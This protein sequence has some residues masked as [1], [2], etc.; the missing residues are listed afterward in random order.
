VRLAGTSIVLIAA[1]SNA[2]DSQFLFDPN[3]NLSS[4]TTEVTAPPQI[5]GQPRNQIVERGETAAFSVVVANTRA[6]AYQWR[7]NGADIT[8]AT[9]DSVVLQNV[10]TNSEGAYRVVL[11]NPSGSVTSAPAMLWFDGNGNGMAD[12]WELL[13]F[14]DLN[15]LPNG[16]F[17]GD[18]SLNLQEFMN[19]T[20]PTDTNSVRFQLTVVRVGGSVIQTPDQSS[21][22]NGQT[23]TLTA[24]A[25]SSATFHAFTGDIATR[26]NPVT[27]VMTNNKTVYASFA[28]LVLN[29][30]NVA[31]GDWNTAA[32][33]EPNLVPGS[34]DCVVI[35]NNVIVTLNTPVDCTDVTLGRSGNSVTTL[36]GSGTLTVHGK[37]SW[38]T[39][40]MSGSGR[41]V[42]EAGSTLTIDNPGPINLMGRA[43]ENGGTVLWSGAGDLA[44]STG[45]VI[46]NRP[47]AVFEARNGG[48]LL[49]SSGVNRFDNAGIFR[50]SDN[51][52][53][54][55]VAASFNNSGTVEIQAGT[56]LCQGG[57]ANSGAVNLSA[58]TT[59]RLVA[60]GSS[61]GM[62]TTPAA[63]MVEW[64]GGTF[65]LNSGAQ[66]NGAGL[67]RI[68]FGTVTANTD[69]TLANLDI[70]GSSFLDGPGT[71]TIANAMNWTGGNM[72]GN[73]R[74]VIPS[75]ATL[76]AAI[77]S[78][79]SLTGR[80]LE[81][82]GTVLWSG[83]GSL[84]MSTGAFITNR[85]GALFHIQNAT[86]LGTFLGG[87]IDNAGI[88]RK[89][90]NAGTTTVP[91]N[92]NNAGT[93][94]IE[95]GT[96][97]CQG[98][99]TNT[100]TVSL[101][102]GTTNRLAAGGFATGAFDTATT[103]MVEWTANNF[104]LGLGAQ[105]NGDGIYRI[106]FG[107]VTA[108]TSLT[109]ENLDLFNGVLAG[110]G[111][112]TINTLMNWTGGGMSGSG[113]TII[114]A[115]GT[116]KAAI[117]AAATLT[118][119]TFESGGTVLWS[120]AGNIGVSGGAVITNRPGA[121]FHV[122]NAATLGDFF[123]GRI[124]NAG[125]FR[126][127][128]SP[129]STPVRI[130]FT[131]YG[132]VDIRS[133]ILAANGG[134][135][136]SPNAALN[137]TLGGTTAGTGYG[138][139]QVAGTVALNGGL[140]VDLLP[141]F[142]PTTNDTFT[143]VTAGTRN[144]TFASFSYPSNVVTMQLSDSPNSVIVQVTDVLTGIPQPVLL[145]PELSGS[146]LKLTWTSVSNA[147]YRVEFNS[148]LTPSNWT[149]LPGDVMGV[150]NTASKLDAL[151]GSNRFYRVRVV[152]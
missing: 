16:D 150:S 132:T 1:F 149:A 22:A 105:L 100:G 62:F 111:D 142:R 110:A 115:G 33:W 88:F 119:R 29:W 104:V 14:G 117:P 124:D 85:P 17:D 2:Q 112:V 9:N 92:F 27:L 131:N 145:V 135:V 70:I 57:F 147:I 61:S 30:T 140:S 13:H 67:Y 44:M 58:G 10:G 65:A 35:A 77:P 25:S 101:S 122:L 109:V 37:F 148:D 76:N 82:G 6:L 7:F 60:G 108:N 59:H 81:N 123:G 11:T 129:G 86:A 23:V 152:P 51:S 50:K 113:R 121:L 116:L 125:V 138:Q 45:A 21:Y 143:V 64:T 48:L 34:K 71:V 28:P 72:S 20:D 73:G 38:I 151:T 74:T 69:L 95:T 107:L 87:R 130:P 40:N 53:T 96:L 15:Q 32:N 134:Y 5:L 31:D 98:G 39:G 106:N 19:D 99:F 127:S 78:I 89:S 63:A 56:L 24:I 66:L 36:T 79:A 97:L 102:A 26:D 84:A 47:G 133:G 55:T 49:S 4:Q 90:S 83:A 141:G 126:K 43:L 68:N 114:P 18:G 120:G 12:S 3:G 93:V 94:E 146:D 144:G 8:G 52:G 75:G 46:T 139:L 136:S 41:T 103:A 54:T 128:G 118:S 80:T 42:L 137:C 91:V